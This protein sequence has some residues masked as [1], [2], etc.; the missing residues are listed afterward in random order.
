MGSHGRVDC[1]NIMMPEVT[2][3]REA[4]LATIQANCPCMPTDVR[5]ILEQRAKVGITSSASLVEVFQGKLPTICPCMTNEVRV[6]IEACAKKAGITAEYNVCPQSHNAHSDNGQSPAS[7]DLSDNSQGM[8]PSSHATPN[9]TGSTSSYSPLNFNDT[10]HV[11]GL[12]ESQYMPKDNNWELL[13]LETPFDDTLG[14]MSSQHYAEFF[15]ESSPLMR[16]S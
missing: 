2:E 15:M 1:V 10:G 4:D 14:S 6:F 13:N 7:M 11:P 12:E 3:V 9:Q 16:E 5:S 8:T